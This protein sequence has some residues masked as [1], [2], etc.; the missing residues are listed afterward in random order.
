[1]SS[2]SSSAFL[3]THR[4]RRSRSGSLLLAACAAAETIVFSVVSVFFFPPP[5][6]RFFSLVKEWFVLVFENDDFVPSR[7]TIA[8]MEKKSLVSP[9]LNRM[10]ASKTTTKTKEAEG[11]RNSR[12]T[13][14]CFDK[15]SNKSLR[16]EKRCQR[17][18]ESSIIMGI[19]KSLL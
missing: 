3:T 12:R 13:S 2:S 11:V 6:S 15:S 8:P 4:H 18:H 19:N 5:L 16:C 10:R 14:R 9:P 1:M 17:K 7:E